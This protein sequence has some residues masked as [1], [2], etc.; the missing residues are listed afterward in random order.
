M[1]DHPIEPHPAQTV[2]WPETEPERAELRRGFW[3]DFARSFLWMLEGKRTR[4]VHG[5]RIGSPIV[6][7]RQCERVIRR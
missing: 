5:W 4:R 7:A 2:L 1:T 3:H 6:A